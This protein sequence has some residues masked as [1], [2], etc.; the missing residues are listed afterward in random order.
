MDYKPFKMKGFPMQKGTGSYL[1]EE[2][3]ARMKKEA[4]AK[5]KYDKS[6]TDERV[7]DLDQKKYDKFRGTQGKEFPDIR[8][9]GKKE[10]KEF[11]EE[12]LKRKDSKVKSISRNAKIKDLL[13]DSPAPQKMSY[14]E[15]FDYMTG[16][17]K[18]DKRKTRKAKRTVKKAIKKGKKMEGEAF[19]GHFMQVPGSM[20]REGTEANKK[21]KEGGFGEGM[22]SAA[23]QK[24]HPAVTKYNKAVKD[25]ENEFKSFIG[26]LHSE[27]RA[28]T[29]GYSKTGGVGGMTTVDKKAAEKAR[30]E[31][32][33][34]IKAAQKQAKKDGLKLT[35]Q[36]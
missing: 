35:K 2:S 29:T 33:K 31:A 6:D 19:P 21:A 30:K 18:S 26:K 5:Q 13:K 27:G 14:K 24:E 1:K 7:Y 23:P 16:E 36:K 15:A 25:A 3:A 32:D 4:A 22:R 34:K 17:D 20:Y 10:N 12:Y 9:L 8:Y 28:D 11:L